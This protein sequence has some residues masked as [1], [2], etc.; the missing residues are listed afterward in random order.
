[1]EG[2]S[3]Y[4]AVKPTF[5][6]VSSHGTKLLNRTLLLIFD[7]D[8]GPVPGVKDDEYKAREIDLLSHRAVLEEG[9]VTFFNNR[10]FDD[11]NEAMRTEHKQVCG[12]PDSKFEPNHSIDIFTKVKTVKEPWLW[13]RLR[14]L[15]DSGTAPSPFNSIH[16][17]VDLTASVLTA[18]EFGAQHYRL[19]PSAVM[20]GMEWEVD[21][22]EWREHAGKEIE[23]HQV[24]SGLPITERIAVKDDQRELVVAALN[25]VNTIYRKLRQVAGEVVAQTVLPVSHLCSSTVTKTL[26]EWRSFFCQESTHFETASLKV[27]LYR[28]FCRHA[29]PLFHGCGQCEKQLS[30][31]RGVFLE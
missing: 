18:L 5:K 16:I 15:L 27:D 19:V 7:Y 4:R 8:L 26:A 1:M 17:T 6:I 20:E 11:P 25:E 29:G 3:H 12:I 10:F 2:Q 24:F 14:E 21:P 9:G 28:Q 22:G 30:A 13:Q 23:V 31:L